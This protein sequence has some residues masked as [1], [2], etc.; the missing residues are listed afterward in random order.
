VALPQIRLVPSRLHYALRSG[1]TPLVGREEEV[2][3]LARRWQQAKSGAYIAR[4]LMVPLLP[5]DN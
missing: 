3:L 5:G 2:E 1:E 4:S